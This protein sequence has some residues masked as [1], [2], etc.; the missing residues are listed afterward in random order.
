MVGLGL[1]LIA[2]VAALMFGN[3]GARLRARVVVVEVLGQGGHFT[4]VRI[5]M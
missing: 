4:R 5:V 3:F 1:A 2:D